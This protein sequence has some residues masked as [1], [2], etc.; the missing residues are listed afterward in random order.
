MMHITDKQITDLLYEAQSYTDRDA[1][2]SDF[3]LSSVWGDSPDA[4]IPEERID[5]PGFALEEVVP[6]E[7]R[8]HLTGGE[9]LDLFRMTPYAW[10]TPRE[11]VERLAALPLAEDRRQ[12]L[13]RAGETLA[14][15]LDLNGEETSCLLDAA[16]DL[17]PR[18]EA[19]LA[20][21]G[22]WQAIFP[23]FS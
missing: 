5:Y 21:G 6:V 18:V 12:L 1:Y 19:V 10:K 14:R 7:T 2:I 15:R 17:A 22:G 16:T 23:A 13:R 20:A 3:A 4:D 11:G 9:A 8:L